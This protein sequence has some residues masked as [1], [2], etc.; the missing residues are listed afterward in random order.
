[1]E[2]VGFKKDETPYLIFACSKCKQ[3]T[4]VK[5][6]QK[7]KKCLR[8]GRQHKVESILNSGEIVNGMTKAVDGVKQKQGEFAIKENDGIL[9]LR[10]A[11]DFTISNKAVLDSVSRKEKTKDADED[12]YNQFKTML[13]E[14]SMTYKKFPYYLIEI[15]GEDYNIPETEIK[16]LFQ[17]SIAKGVLNQIEWNLYK[18][19]T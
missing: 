13:S 17:T 3:F 15:M 12:Y 11:G 9:E 16:I 1:M 6:T 10:S 14:L 4:Y 19:N 18:L 7:G 8:C 5:T 2:E